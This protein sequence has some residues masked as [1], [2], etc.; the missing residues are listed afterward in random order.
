MCDCVYL[1][2]LFRLVS[3]L[4]MSLSSPAGIACLLC[5]PSLSCPLQALLHNSHLYH[6][7]RHEFAKK[8]IDIVYITCI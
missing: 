8:G 5:G 4:C 7:T 6:M 1:F 3:A 2:E